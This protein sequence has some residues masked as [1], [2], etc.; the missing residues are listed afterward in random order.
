MVAIPIGASNTRFL[1][2]DDINRSVR[3]PFV[4]ELFIKAGIR[5]SPWGGI[6]K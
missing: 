5:L 6:G 4:K 3:P 1:P 2:P